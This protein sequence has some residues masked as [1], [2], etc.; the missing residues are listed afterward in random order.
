MTQVYVTLTPGRSGTAK[1]AAIMNE[2]VGMYGTHEAEPCYSRVL[3]HSL[4]SRPLRAGFAAS[5]ILQIDSLKVQN[6][7]DTSF[8][9]AYGFI[10]EFIKLGRIPNA[11]HLRRDHTLVA[12]SMLQLGSIPTHSPDHNERK[13]FMHPNDPGALKFPDWWSASDYQ[14]CY[15]HCLNM[16]NL[17]E[18]YMHIISMH[19]GKVYTIGAGHLNSLEHINAMLTYFELPN[20]KSVSNEILNSKS[21]LKRDIIPRHILREQQEVEQAVYEA[22]DFSR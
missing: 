10:E 2:V 9:A 20:L 4:H 8:M 18:K 5:K 13:Y 21:E 6:Y 22:R 17:A 3:G 16:E 1:L 12:L 14:L 7:C 11:I 19:G 15:W